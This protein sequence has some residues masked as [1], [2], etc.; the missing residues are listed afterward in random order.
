MNVYPLVDDM[1]GLCGTVT[2]LL[3]YHRSTAGAHLT[4]IMVSWKYSK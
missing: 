4:E 3:V 1:E 2:N